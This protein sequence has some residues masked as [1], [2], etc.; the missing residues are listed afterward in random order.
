MM[1]NLSIRLTFLISHAMDHFH[2][3]L[4]VQKSI[5]PLSGNPTP[6]LDP[7]V[8][9]LSTSLIPFG[10]SDFILEEIDTFL[11]SY[12][13]TS[14]DADDGT[15]N[16]EGD[17]HLIDKSSIDV[18]PHLELK[19]LPSYLEYAFLEIIRRCVDGQEAMGILQ[20]C[21]HG[22]T[23]GHH[24]P[25]YT[26]KK[27]FDS[28]FFWPTVYRDA[29]D[30]ICEIFDVWG[31]DFM[32]LFPSS[33]GNKYILV[34]VDYV[35]KWVKAKALPTNDARVVVEVSNHGLKRILERT[36]GEHRAKWVDKLDDALWAFRIAFKTPIDCTSYKIVLKV[37]SS[38]LKSH[39]SGTFTVAKVF[40]YRTVE[41][42]QPNGPNF[43]V[44]G[45]RIKHYYGGDIPAMDVPDLH[46]SPKD[47]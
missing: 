10:H 29:H 6:S 16:M 8:A 32:G 23:R 5:N 3:V 31:I 46:L 43:K 40:P 38:K 27:V 30:M 36:V 39:W 11:A 44:N 15:F 45:H 24:G 9:S 19:D 14:L 2:E 7:V 26:A 47:N 17:I 12:D 41:L 21:H 4:N 25:N 35:S 18:P 33:R 13:S 28:G 37:F 20:A 1:M 42:S 34:S 22:S